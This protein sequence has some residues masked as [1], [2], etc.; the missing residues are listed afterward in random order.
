MRCFNIYQILDPDAG[1]DT[2]GKWCCYT[3]QNSLH[4]FLRRDGE[5]IDYSSDAVPGQSDLFFD[6]LE[7]LTRVLGVVRLPD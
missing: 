3:S 2:F 1:Q 4:L 7:D 5:W 6:S